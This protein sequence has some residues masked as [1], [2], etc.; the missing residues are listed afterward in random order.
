MLLEY[1]IKH[2]TTGEQWTFPVEG[3]AGVSVGAVVV[4]VI[5]VLL[6]NLAR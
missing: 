4:V 5:V 6:I 3:I 2:I 1:Y